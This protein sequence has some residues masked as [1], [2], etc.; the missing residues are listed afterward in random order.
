MEHLPGR[1][2]P[3]RPWRNV[4]GKELVSTA[5]G[6]AG[7]E[8][9]NG[10]NRRQ[11]AEGTAVVLRN[12]PDAASP[13]PDFQISNLKSQIGNLQVISPFPKKPRVTDCRQL[14]NGL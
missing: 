13:S 3:D 12:Q 10:Q 9:L 8:L 11:M 5:L 2:N 1:R 4:L 14:R 7:M 6:T